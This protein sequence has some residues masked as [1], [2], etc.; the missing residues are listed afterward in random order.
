[1]GR[2]IDSAGDDDTA[3]GVRL[4]PRRG[5]ECGDGQVQFG[6]AGDHAAPCGGVTFADRGVLHAVDEGRGWCAVG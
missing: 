1:M 3:G 6:D 2:T 5:V 4:D